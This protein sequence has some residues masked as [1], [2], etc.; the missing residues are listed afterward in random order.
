[1]G[2]CNAT[3]PDPGS[4]A[5]DDDADVDDEDAAVAVAGAATVVD[6]IPNSWM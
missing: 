4:A 6:A 2:S 5:V 1:M 3:P